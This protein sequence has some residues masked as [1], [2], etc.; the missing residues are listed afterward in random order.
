LLETSIFFDKEL[1]LWCDSRS[2]HTNLTEAQISDRKTQLK[3]GQQSSQ[4]QS[5]PT[6][7]T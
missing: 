5:K 3:S 4:A 1:D 2:Q 6:E 7:K